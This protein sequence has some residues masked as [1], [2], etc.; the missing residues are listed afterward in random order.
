[1]HA[2]AC[3]LDDVFREL[4]LTRMFAVGESLGGWLALDYATR[5]P[6]R[7]DKMAL[8][9]PVGIGRRK[10][11]LLKA[12]PLM[13]LGSW[14]ARKISEM[15][16]GPVPTTLTPEARMFSDFFALVMSSFRTRLIR[17]PQF[18]D[19]SLLQLTMPI[20]FLLAG[21]EVFFDSAD[22]KRRLE[23]ILPHAKVHLDPE[24]FHLI[25]NRAAPILEFL[26]NG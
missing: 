12:L 18:T 4:N 25:R 19:A 22:T 17:I 24:A 5:R 6:G 2:H 10:N 9:V 26:R 15:I 11:L 1:M 16:F 8:L 3:W 14:G 13:L 7:I 21:K 23:K 20:M